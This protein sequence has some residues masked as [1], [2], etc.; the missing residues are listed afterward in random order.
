MKNWYIIFS[1]VTLL[2]SCSTE[3]TFVHDYNYKTI[4]DER[5]DKYDH[6]HFND[7]SFDIYV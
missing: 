6:N 2:F 5:P 7:K 1:L 3:R 4:I